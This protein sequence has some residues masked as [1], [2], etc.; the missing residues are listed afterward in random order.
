MSYRD[1]FSSINCQRIVFFEDDFKQIAFDKTR[2]LYDMTRMDVKDRKL[3]LDEIKTQSMEL[4]AK[5]RAFL[6][7]FD[8]CFDGIGVWR[9][10]VVLCSLF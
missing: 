1:L 6:E 8:K 10:S 5:I 3:F 9:D 4:E 7:S 2:M